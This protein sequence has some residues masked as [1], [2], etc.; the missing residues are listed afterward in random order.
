MHTI[1]THTMH[2]VYD[3]KPHT[4]VRTYVNTVTVIWWSL[5]IVVTLRTPTSGCCREVACIRRLNYTL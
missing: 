2:L 5:S 1:S 4:Y 3:I